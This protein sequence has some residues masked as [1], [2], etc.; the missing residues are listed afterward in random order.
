MTKL[1]AISTALVLSGNAGEGP[2]GV[3]SSS[4][5]L[6]KLAQEMQFSVDLCT[7]EAIKEAKKLSKQF[8]SERAGKYKGWPIKIVVDVGAQTRVRWCS[9][10]SGERHYLKVS[11]LTHATCLTRKSSMPKEL[12]ELQVNYETKLIAL[13]IKLANLGALKK[14]LLAFV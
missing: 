1:N 5:M 2:Q 7:Q 11:A 6:A 13:R 14:I 9:F 3:A 10:Y 4:E 12:K 8:D